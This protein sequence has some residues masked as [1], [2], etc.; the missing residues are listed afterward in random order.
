MSKDKK[1]SRIFDLPY[2]DVSEIDLLSDDTFRKYSIQFS[3]LDKVD[4]QLVFIIAHFRGVELVLNQYTRQVDGI[5]YLMG[6]KI[7]NTFKATIVAN[8]YIKLVAN[9]WTDDRYQDLKERLDNCESVYER[10]DLIVAETKALEE[11]VAGRKW[12]NVYRQAYE[13]SELGNENVFEYPVYGDFEIIKLPNDLLKSTILFNASLAVTDRSYRIKLKKLEGEVASGEYDRSL[14]AREQAVIELQKGTIG[15]PSGRGDIDIYPTQHEVEPSSPNRIASNPNRSLE[16]ALR[17]RKYM[18]LIN[19][20]LEDCNVTE[21]GKCVLPK[22]KSRK[23]GRLFAIIAALKDD[24]WKNRLLK[25]PEITDEDL[26]NRFNE[27]L[28]IQYTQV[29]KKSDTFNETLPVALTFLQL[30]F[31]K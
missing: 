18:A 2:N 11:A 28:N 5:E 10:T 30:N 27:Y 23:A 12:D 25:N 24:K 9:G 26:L 21:N 1:L 7:D 15:I 20:L 8:K 19:E 22:E 3:N 4:D 17:E 16:S 13:Q 14:R 31:K 29:K 6:I